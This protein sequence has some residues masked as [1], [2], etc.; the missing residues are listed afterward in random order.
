MSTTATALAAHQSDCKHLNFKASVDVGR[1]SHDP[2]GPITGYTADVRVNCADC[3]LAFRFVGIAAGNHYAEPRVSMDGT[4]LRAPIE[5]AIHEKFAPI[6]RY[7]MPPREV[8]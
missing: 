5:P 7:V 2:G 4:E 1:L 3:G 8:N 6:A